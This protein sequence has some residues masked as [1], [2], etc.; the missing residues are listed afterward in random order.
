M[1]EQPPKTV[2]LAVHRQ[3]LLDVAD[4]LLTQGGLTLDARDRSA[5]EPTEVTRWRSVAEHFAAQRRRLDELAAAL[6]ATEALAPDGGPP[7]DPADD[8][9]ADELDALASEIETWRRRRDEAQARHARLAHQVADLQTLA[10]LELPTRPPAGEPPLLDCTVG[11]VASPFLA[12][13]TA[14]ELHTP[15]LVV[16]LAD[17][18]TGADSTL[19]AAAAPP[20]ASAVLERFLRSLE[21][22]ALDLPDG[23]LAD[24]DD[25]LHALRTEI[26]AAA[27]RVGELAHERDRLVVEYGARM[28]GLRRLY[29]AE[30]R[31]ARLLADHAGFDALVFFTGLLDPGAERRFVHRVHEVAT[32][33]HVIVL[34]L[35]DPEAA[36]A[37]HDAQEGR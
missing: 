7:A 14:P 30:E 15:L 21:F 32:H 13:A 12:R 16:P 3:D 8:L 20:A 28:A 36:P 26:E 22:A 2:T 25:R 6:E 4:V 9:D 29:A 23:A 35:A 17:D 33:D 11:H 10:D 1:S 18:A 5:R 37:P 24:P 19:V 31:R 27:T 34:G